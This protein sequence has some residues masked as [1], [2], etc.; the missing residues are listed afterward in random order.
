[1]VLDR[2]FNLT[3]NKTNPR[4][5]MVAGLTTFLTMAYILIVNPAILSSTGMDLGAVFTATAVSSFVA[6]MMMG[7][8]ANIPVALALDWGSTHFSP[9]LLFCRWGIVGRWG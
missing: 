4:Q 2:L 9:T 7:L 1:M 8:L 5:E 6:C 3:K